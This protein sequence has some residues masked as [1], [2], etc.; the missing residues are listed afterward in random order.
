MFLFMEKHFKEY[1]QLED[2]VHLQNRFDSD[3]NYKLT[4]DEFCNLIF[5]TDFSI[6]VIFN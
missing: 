5:P 4:I 1:Y 2:Y 3:R 6:N